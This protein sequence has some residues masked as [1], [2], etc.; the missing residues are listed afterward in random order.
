[1]KRTVIN[2]ATGSLS[3]PSISEKEAQAIRAGWSDVQ[4]TKEKTLD[5]II[6]EKVKAEIEKTKEVKKMS[7]T[8]FWGYSRLVQS[9]T[10]QAITGGAMTWGSSQF[11]YTVPSGHILRLTDFQFGSKF[12][13][14]RASYLVLDNIITIPDATGTVN[15]TTP[16]PISAGTT[17]TA[18]FINN[19]KEQQWLSCLI[20]GT[21]E[22]IN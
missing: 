6:A 7:D 14:D 19:D 12:P 21:L 1:M 10:E 8:V 16:L 9:Y 22:V 13:D 4:I 11:P 17:I 18:K 2:T 5:D 20:I 3:E 15:L